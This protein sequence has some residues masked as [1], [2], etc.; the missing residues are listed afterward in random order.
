MKRSFPHV[1]AAFYGSAWAI[2]PDKLREIEAV[3]LRRIDGGA[4]GREPVAFDDD[5]PMPRS[6][7]KRQ[8]QM[9]GAAAII[10]IHGTIT[11]RPSVFADWSG[12]TSAEQ[13]GRAVDAAA[14]DP[15]ASAIVLDI[16]SP[17]GSV[18]GLPETAAKILAARKAKPVYAVAN[19]MAASAAYW[20]ASQAS[21]IAVTPAGQVGSVGVLWAH[22]DWSAFEETVGRKTTYIHAGKFKVEGAPEFPLDADAA[23]EMQ[24]V[25][26]AYY[27]QFVAGV[28]KGR[29]VSAQKVEDKFGQ[30]RMKLADEAV[31][32]RMADR[33]ATLEQ[34]VNE[35]NSKRA[36]RNAK[37]VAADLAALGLP[38]A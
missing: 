7:Q 6:E 12:G 31:E 2:L 11:P 22:T 15:Q 29:G 5:M 8:Y 16:D 38:T 21:E 19:H 3:L 28:A 26:D 30:G 34:V 4:Q 18:F 36:S 10:P 27:A 35:I 1:L 33:V 32:S 25:V 14:A 13:I 37:R 24:R 20:F 17:G 23:A 9:S